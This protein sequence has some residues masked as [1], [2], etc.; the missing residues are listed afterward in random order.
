MHQR[1]ESGRDEEELAD[2]RRTGERDQ[3]LVALC[4]ADERQG[5]LDDGEAEGEDEGE[6]ADLDDHWAAVASPSF[7]RPE[8]LRASATF[9]GM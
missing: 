6:M 3:R 7:H 8:R 4:G 5:A 9:L 2:R 1:Q